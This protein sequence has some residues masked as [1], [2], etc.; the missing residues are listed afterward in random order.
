[1][2]QYRVFNTECGYMAISATEK[3]LTGVA[4]PSGSVE[5][6]L[7]QLGLNVP[8]TVLSYDLLPDF[9]TS[10][11]RYF[12]GEKIEFR[13]E[14]DFMGATDFQLRVWQAAMKI[15]WG[16]TRSY[17]WVAAQAGNPGA[18]RATGNA[19]GRNP[20]PI[21]VPCH[22]V[23][24]GDGSIGGFS[25]GLDRKRRLLALESVELSR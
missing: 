21:V 22:R 9:T 8:D 6:A 11:K 24:A 7:F 15:P 5:D 19:L 20:V 14:I 16:E 13:V 12:Q 10:M 2:E 3:G 1:M 17:G 4:L 25:S 18:S 23:I